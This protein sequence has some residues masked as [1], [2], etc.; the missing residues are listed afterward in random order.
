MSLV[1]LK[2]KGLAS[3]KN[4]LHV[5]KRCLGS[6][7]NTCSSQPLL[8]ILNLGTLVT[9]KILLPVMLFDISIEFISTIYFNN[10]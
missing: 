2:R 5:L 8:L 10:L 7:T 1:T 3:R 9:H 6:Q 4:L